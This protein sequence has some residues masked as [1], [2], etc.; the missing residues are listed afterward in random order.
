MGVL[1]MSL[2]RVTDHCGL[3]NLTFVLKTFDVIFDGTFWKI[4]TPKRPIHL[5]CIF[6]KRVAE[7]QHV[8][9]LG[10]ILEILF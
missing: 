1:N 9:S 2:K 8:S 6:A 10:D 3:H 7:G 5:R 4:S